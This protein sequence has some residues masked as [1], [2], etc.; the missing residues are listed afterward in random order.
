MSKAT[1]LAKAL[2]VLCS[3]GP[4][5]VPSGVS[6]RVAR[7]CDAATYK[8]FPPRGGWQSGS[9]NPE[10]HGAFRRTLFQQVCGLMP[11]SIT[12]DGFRCSGRTLCP[13][14]HSGKYRDDDC[15]YVQN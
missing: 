3:L 1:Y 5:W 2:I 10:W 7:K 12:N 11:N 9:C 8:A 6:L 4:M 14:S 15:R 13:V